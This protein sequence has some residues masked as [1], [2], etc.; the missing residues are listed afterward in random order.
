LAPKTP[1]L[2]NLGFFGDFCGFFS[3]WSGSGPICNY[4]LEA[5][6]LAVNFPNSQG[7]WC[8]LQQS[9]GLICEMVRNKEFPDLFSKRKLR[10]SGPPCVDRAARPSPRWTSGWRGQEGARAQ[11]RA[12]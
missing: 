1:L 4:F 6:G 8:N 5:E 10:G 9:Q 3:L 7:P 12:H 2:R 11:E